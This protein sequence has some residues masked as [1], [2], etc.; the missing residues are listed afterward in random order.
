MGS[1][2]AGSSSIS[3]MEVAFAAFFQQNANHPH[4][5]LETVHGSGVAQNQSSFFPAIMGGET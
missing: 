4:G 3:P 2:R 1:D 5:R